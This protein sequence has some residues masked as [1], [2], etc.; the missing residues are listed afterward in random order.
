MASRQVQKLSA[1]GPARSAR[2]SMKR[3]WAWEW[4]FGMAGTAMP[5]MRSPS[6]PAPTWVIMPLPSTVTVTSRFQASGVSTL[7]K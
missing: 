3:W 1:P 2:P 5:V 6:L 7:A 4:T